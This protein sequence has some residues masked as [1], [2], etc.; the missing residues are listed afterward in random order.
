[1]A[2]HKLDQNLI[3]KIAAGEV[4]ERPASVVKELIENSLDANATKIFVE[5]REAGKSYIKVEDDGDGM[6]EEDAIFCIERHSTSKIKD[7]N[8]LFKIKTLGFRGEALA[9][10]AAISK[11]RIITKTEDSLEGTQVHILNGKVLDKR[12]VG[13]NKGTIIEVQ[14]LFYNT[15]ARKK[16]LK[17]IPTE[18]RH[19]VDVITRY[20]LSNPQVYFQLIHN[21]KLVFNA[22]STNDTFNNIVNIYGRSVAKEMLPVNYSN[23]EIEVIGF[24]SKPALTRVDRSHQTFFVNGRYVQN[25][26]ISRALNDAYGT[27]LM[28]NRKPVAVLN[29]AINPVKIDVN[30]H[31]TKREIKFSNEKELYNTVFNAVK[32][33]LTKNNL[34]RSAI[35]EDAKLTPLGTVKAKMEVKHGYDLVRDEQS[36][37]DEML[38]SDRPLKEIMEDEE[39][40][41][42]EGILPKRKDFTVIGQLN[43][44]Y[45]LIED[46]DGL[47]I[48]DQHVAEERPNY[49]DFMRQFR[50]KD[51]PTQ[52]LINPIVLELDPRNKIILESNLKLIHELGFDVDEFGDGSFILRAVPVIMGKEMKKEILLDIIDE[53]SVL[54]KT[55]SLEQ[56]QEKVITRMACRASIMAGEELTKPQMIKIV[57]RLFRSAQPHTCPHGRPTMIRMSLK[58][59]EKK[60][61]RVI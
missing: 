55:I 50:H 3:N 34:T 47:A 30:V 37:L 42:V 22:P 44:T 39:D 40:I 58:D 33:T 10:I 26:V 45:I 27:L 31:P 57:D 48:I 52:T 41:M 2:I 4:I 6:T 17:D 13:C 14:N 28:V 35:E 20:S 53:I 29:I 60:F 46:D 21:N 19:I 25:I 23:G 49:E 16:Y 43:K 5:I 61:K 56:L 18:L 36:I 12:T 38:K 59:L 32:E 24:V 1:M 11:M 54:S 15:P 7:I 8:D 9:S 51:V